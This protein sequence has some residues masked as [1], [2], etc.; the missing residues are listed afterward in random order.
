MLP[1]PS[2][3]LQVS[4]G[5]GMSVVVS[6]G[7]AIVNGCLKL[8]ETQR[9]LAIQS[10]GTSYDRIDTVVMRLD[11]NDEARNCDLYVLEGTPA[12]S[13]VR[14]QLTRTGTVW[15]IGLADIFVAKNTAAV[16]NQRITD[17]RY[18]TS[19]CG[20]I[21]SISRFDTTTLYQQVQSDL[22]EFQ[23]VSETEFL[24]WYKNIKEQLSEDAAGNLQNQIGN[25]E[26]LGTI[27]KVNLVN[28]I[29]E[30]VVSTESVSTNIENV[31]VKADSAAKEAATADSAARDAKSTAEEATVTANSATAAANSATVVA[32]NAQSMAANA[33]EKANS[34]SAI[35]AGLQN[36]I[37]FI[38]NMQLKPTIL[39]WAK[40][41]NG[42]MIGMMV[43]PYR[44]GD[45]PEMVVTN[46]SEWTI[47]VL[48]QPGNKS[49][50]TVI[51]FGYGGGVAA[52]LKR[53]IW[54]GNWQGSWA[55]IA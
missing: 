1:N 33:I 27:D 54:D 4:A 34:A 24:S 5:T 44:P 7:F 3:N 36:Y 19:R 20:V 48:G 22:A 9:T 41:C 43:N 47:L 39:E 46:V 45:G 10:S 25:L 17:T 30:V 51:A 37:T 21:S 32:N 49:R 31:K 28:A 52:T 55:A 50:Q 16:S 11:D 14:P 35:V 8:E 42:L 13:P 29:N 26:Q 2:S 38:P 18:E 15:E 40:E 6:P 23:N 12:T 53:N